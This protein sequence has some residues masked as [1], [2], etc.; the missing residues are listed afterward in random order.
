MS[1]FGADNLLSACA[2]Q[3]RRVEP[4]A[5]FYLSGWGPINDDVEGRRDLADVLTSA[6]GDP[7]TPLRTPGWLERDHPKL[8]ER[9]EILIRLAEYAGN[10]AAGFASGSAHIQLLDYLDYFMDLGAD[11][12]RDLA[13]QLGCPADIALRMREE[14]IRQR[15]LVDLGK[16]GWAHD[17]VLRASGDDSREHEQIR[18]FVDTLY[19]AVLA[20]SARAQSGYMSSVPRSDDREQL[21]QVN[22]LAMEI[23]RRRR[24]GGRPD[25]PEGRVE[26]IAPT[27]SGVFTAAT[28]SPACPPR[29]CGS[30]SPRTGPSSP[31]T[32]AGRRGSR[33]APG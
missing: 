22:A 10:P 31:T 30:C 5:K 12:V 33:A 14:I 3:F 23:I 29:R 7:R 8:A 9:F 11:E 2:L 18:E 15:T 4:G 28:P 26:A 17:L 16:R 19:N 27:L 24:H 13:L 32:T 6:G 20:D 1:W 25:Q 21:K